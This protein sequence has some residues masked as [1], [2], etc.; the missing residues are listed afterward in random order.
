MS[1]LDDLAHRDIWVRWR[2]EKRGGKP[3]KVPAA[4]RRWTPSSTDPSTWASREEA[5]RGN[6]GDG[7]GIILAPLGANRHLGGIDLDGCMNDDG[8]VAQWGAR[9]R[10]ASHELHRGQ[11]EWPRPQDLLR[12]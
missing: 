11:P 5:E 10:R 7:L 9:H 12:T 6:H 1:A 3:T 4:D 2:S 8:D